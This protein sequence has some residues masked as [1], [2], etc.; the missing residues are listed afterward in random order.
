MPITINGTSGIT[1][2]NATLQ[3]VAA[4]APPDVQTFNASGTWTKP[5]IGSMARIQVWGGGGGGNRAASGGAA[6]GA[7]GGYSELTVPLSTLGSTVTVT[8]GAAGVGRTGTAGAGTAGGNSTFGSLVGATGGQSNGGIGGSPFIPPSG[9]AIRL[10][11]STGVCIFD[12]GSPSA[13]SGDSLYGGATGGTGTNTAGGGSVG[14]VSAYGGAGG[15]G[16]G[17]NIVAVAGT[18]PAGGGGGGYSTGLYANGADGGSGRVV[19]TVW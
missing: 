16:A 3:A 19:V 9:T 10:E 5:T 7:G 17:N 11:A 15:R 8:V 6:P 18:T 4:P 12:G 2:P 1:F 13:W 14:G